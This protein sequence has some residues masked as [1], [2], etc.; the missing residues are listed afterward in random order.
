MAGKKIIKTRATSLQMIRLKIV[1]RD[2]C[3]ITGK[4]KNAPSVFCA[5]INLLNTGSCYV[6]LS[7]LNKKEGQ[8]GIIFD[9]TTSEVQ[10][11]ARNT[12]VEDNWLGRGSIRVFATCSQLVGIL[13]Q[14]FIRIF[15]PKH[16]TNSLRLKAFY[17]YKLSQNRETN[18]LLLKYSVK[19]QFHFF[20]LTS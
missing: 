7:S 9:R 19:F 10:R 20:I 15:S 8:I 3:K 12:K 17:G 4:L 2:N 13:S 5:G 11:A 1:K 6:S 14:N 18:V 16:V